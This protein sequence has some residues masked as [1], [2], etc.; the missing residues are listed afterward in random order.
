[1]WWSRGYDRASACFH[2]RIGLDGE[3]VISPRRVRVQA[4][5]TIVYARSGKL[6]WTGPWREAVEAG[7]RVLLERCIRPDGGTHHQLGPDGQPLDRRRDLYDLAF[8][9][10]ALAEAGAVLRRPDLI[11][12]SERL[13]DWAYEAWSHPRGGFQEGDV[14]PV[15]PRRQNPHM[16]MFEAML[17]LYEVTGERK[18]LERASAIGTL[19]AEGFFDA[20]LGALPEY[21]DDAWRPRDGEE[22]KICE[23]G[24]QFEWSW[25]LHRWNALGGG[26]L[27]AAA[28]R[29]R[30]HGETFGVDSVSGAV[31]DEM[32]LG[33]R[34]RMRTSRL[35]PH[36]ERLK[37]NIVAFER[38]GDAGAAQAAA[39]AFD[40]LM[41][42]CDTPVRGLWRDKLQPD[43]AFVEEPAPA[44]SFYHIMI[45]LDEL[46][47]VSDTTAKGASF[48]RTQHR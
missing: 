14:T 7:V 15:P 1:M 6:G 2:E 19:F 46:M 20:R 11:A 39:Q 40:V 35:W 43:G 33:G 38:T 22:G 24:H 23:P 26:D 4:R 30:I 12:A 42:Y 29:L 13:T 8:V 32:T 5:Q 10:F 31:H 27:G 47:R 45:A 48:A 44:S 41:R 3:P 28:E 21:F 37:A 18:H 25:L 36:T 34:A 17:A 9:V 16:H